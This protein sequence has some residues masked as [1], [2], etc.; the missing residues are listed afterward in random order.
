M[1]SEISLHFTLQK[2]E[3]RVYFYFIASGHYRRFVC[4]IITDIKLSLT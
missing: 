1:S 3:G 2:L 4:L